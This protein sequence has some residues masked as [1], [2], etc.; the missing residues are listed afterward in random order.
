[1]FFPEN[2]LQPIVDRIS[3]DVDCNINFMDT[4]GYIVASANKERIG[5]FHKAAKE[6]ISREEPVAINREN[7]HRYT[8]AKPGINQPFYYE[9]DLVGVFGLTG[10]PEKI[11]DYTKI[12]KSMLELMI[13]QEIMKRKMSDRQTNKVFF[14]H[15]LLRSGDGPEYRSGLENSARALGYDLSLPRAALLIDIEELAREQARSVKLMSEASVKE[16]V[17]FLLKR[18]KGHSSRDISSFVSTYT[19]L[20][21]KSLKTT[22]Y[23]DGEHALLG[24]SHEI[25]D[26]L[27]QE[28]R[29]SPEL[30]IGSICCD[31]M[32]LRDSYREAL[33]IVSEAKRLKRLP[34]VLQEGLS[35]S[36][37]NPSIQ[38]HML[39]FM[40]K[41]MEKQ[42]AERFFARVYERIADH[43]ELLETIIALT[44][45]DMN[46]LES[47]AI[48]GVHR[49][50]VLFRLRKLYTLTEIDP[51]NHHGDRNFIMLFAQYLRMKMD[52]G[53]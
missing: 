42:R 29:I 14:I 10:E 40:F 11:I 22:R 36:F 4:R 13:S 16:R 8:G 2:L 44:M 12:V 41:H 37:E 20:V 18:Q 34:G 43:T 7:Q 6:A 33:F 28:F 23:P 5:C 19:L 30:G 31:V 15:E 24:Y 49:N 21:L 47:S 9:G 27:E 3:A 38:H 17:L 52:T 50:T 53:G 48:L 25:R 1:M 39:D 26:A 46:V 35:R 45:A 32:E 51:I